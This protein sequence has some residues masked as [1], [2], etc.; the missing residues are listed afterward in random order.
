MASPTVHGRVLSNRKVFTPMSTVVRAVVPADHKTENLT[1]TV[2]GS[3]VALDVNIASGTVNVSA[4]VGGA[5]SAKQDAQTT[6]LT[7]IN[8]G[9]AG[10][11]PATGGATSAKQDTGNTSLASIDGKITA[12]NTGA[13][14]VSSS[15]LPSGA[16]TAAN[17]TTANTSLAS[18][19]TK[20]PSLVSGRQ[21]VD[22]SGV[23]QPVSA[24]SLPLPTG[25]ATETTLAAL[26]TKVTAVNTGAVVL[27][28]GVATIGNV[29]QNGTWTVQPGN[30]A[31][32]TA[33]LVT[34]STSATSTV[35]SV[36]SSATT[37]SILASNTSRKGAMFFNESTA[38]CYLK[39]GATA[40]TTS[41]TVQ[42]AASGFFEMPGPKIYTGAIDAIWASANGSLRITEL[43]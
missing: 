37:V 26:N 29:G 40:S 42:I 3:A 30:T 5:T 22:G 11:T 12:V 35:T 20:T 15:A 32:T 17:Q 18:L 6:L 2:T 9:I 27:T 23:T 28:T 43:S 31:N 39:F 21:P 16:A 10:I 34:E 36:A 1:A 38:I 14:V 33:W 41:Y 8:T 25:A 19:D 7:S 13:V 24:A 4:P